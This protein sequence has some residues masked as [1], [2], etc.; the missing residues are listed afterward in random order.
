MKIPILQRALKLLKMT[1]IFISALI[2]TYFISAIILS[3][4]KTHPPKLGCPFEHEIF[5][6]TNGVHLDIILPIEYI[7][8]EFLKK[9][10]VIHQAK[11][12]AFGW[13]D[14]Q[15]YLNTPEWTDLTF[16]T[17]F[18]ALFLKSE[19]A[20]HVTCYRNSYSSWRKIKLCSS[21][22]DA[23]TRYIENSFQKDQS[24]G[25]QK[26]EFPGYYYTDIFYEANESFTLFRTC[27]VWVNKALKVSGVETSV[28]SPFDL[29]VLYHLP[30]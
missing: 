14:K 23:L 15:F 2:V 29:G 21:Q 6:S 9:L 16:K 27:N 10:E 3:V 24:G 4:L 8:T 30:E 17:A 26:I 25:F 12:I 11:Y 18:K 19:S 20:M 28:W 5:I 22:L 1:G 13:G 7:D